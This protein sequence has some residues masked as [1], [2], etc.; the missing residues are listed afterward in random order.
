MS[1]SP[2]LDDILVEL[3]EGQ[4]L[5]EVELSAIYARIG[6]FERDPEVPWFLHPFIFAGALLAAGL[7]TVG[8]V[9]TMN[10]DPGGGAMLGMGSLYIAVAV[11]MHR[12]ARGDFLEYLGLS[13]S[14]GGHA[15]II[16]G[17]IEAAERSNRELSVLLAVAVLCVLLYRIQ[18]TFLHRFFSCALVFATARIAL[19]EAGIGDGLHAM[20]AA[21]AATCAWSLTRQ[22]QDPNWVPL[23]Y[24]SALGLLGLVLPIG[25]PEFGMENF[26]LPHR[27]ISSGACGIALLWA[28]DFAATRSSFHVRTPHRTIAILLV[29]GLGSLSTPGILAAVFLIVLGHAGHHWPVALMGLA[30]LP[31]FVWNY[32]YNLEIDLMTKSSALAGSGAV[33]LL[34]RWFLTR[35]TQESS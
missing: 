11:V 35:R 20:V 25:D 19:P 10:F 6:E 21:A 28:L 8:I 9:A 32:Y 33:L 12:S 17:V 30:G 23:A 22:R 7:M 31:I 3:Q 1:D 14:I 34:A 4:Q 29:V 5:D 16:V 13:Y 15:F 24:A 26:A 18:T 27:Y 2:T